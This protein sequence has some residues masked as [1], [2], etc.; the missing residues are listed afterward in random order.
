MTTTFLKK[1]PSLENLILKCSYLIHR[2]NTPTNI[3]DLEDFKNDFINVNNNFYL[4]LLNEVSLSFIL[5]TGNN[6]KG[7][8]DFNGKLYNIKSVNKGTFLININKNN[9]TIIEFN[10]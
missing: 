10:I 7:K 6:F 3:I 9:L 8:I 2:S 4:K 1:S 5:K